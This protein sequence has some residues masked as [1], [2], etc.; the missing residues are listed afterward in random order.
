MVSAG[1]LVKQ[2]A[3]EIFLGISADMVEALSILEDTGVVVEQM[4]SGLL[5][6][7]G[8]YGQAL[9][10]LTHLQLNFIKPLTEGV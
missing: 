6:L 7:E 2:E 9:V 4:F 1:W 5:Q 3:A 8:P 10:K